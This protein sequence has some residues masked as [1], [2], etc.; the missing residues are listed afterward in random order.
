VDPLRDA[1]DPLPVGHQFEHLGAEPFAEFH[2]PL[3]M[4]GRAKVA[5]FA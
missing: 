4:A 5:A 1:K 2:H 3:L